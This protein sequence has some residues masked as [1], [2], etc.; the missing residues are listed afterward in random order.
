MP[1]VMSAVKSPS[2]EILGA[3]TATLASLEGSLRELSMTGDAGSAHAGLLSAAASARQ[4][5]DSGFTGDRIAEAHKAA[6]LFES[7]KARVH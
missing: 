6:A 5:V 2:P 3:L 1:F 4:A 7:A